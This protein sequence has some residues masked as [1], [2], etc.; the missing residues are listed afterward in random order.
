[1][2][3]FCLF[4]CCLLLFPVTV[5]AESLRLNIQGVE[6]DLQ[7]ILE[8]ALVLP[9]LL[10]SDETLNK[11]RLRYYQRQLPKTVNDILEPY[12][13]FHSQASSSLVQIEPGEY[14]L[15]I[16]VS[17]GEPLRISSFTLELSGPGADLPELYQRLDDFPLKVGD[18]LR[19]DH[20]DEGKSTLK[21]AAINIG[22]LDADF[23]RHQLLVN[24]GE[25]RVEIVLQ[26][27]SG[28]RYQFGKTSFSGR[29]NYPER[30]LRRFLVY[31]EGDNFSYNTL[32]RSQLSFL[33]ADLFRNVKVEALTEQKDENRIPVQIELEQL[34]RHRLRPGIGYGTDTGAR[35][36]LQYRELNLFERGHELQGELLIAER[37]QSILTTYIIPDL[38][39]RDSQTLFRVGVT[40]EE[41]DSYI[42]RKQ[43]SEGEYQR[44]YGKRLTG[45][46][47]LRL[48]SE[49]SRVADEST[50]SQMLLP[51]VRLAWKKVDDLL[52]PQRGILAS[53]ELQGSQESLL[54]DTSL[55]QLSGQVSTLMPLP[56]QSSLF[57]R[58][59]G[60][61][62]W[63]NDALRNLPASLRYFAGGD[64]SVRGYAYQSLGPK[65]DTGE[66][67]GGKHL[68]V[69]NLE[70]EKHLTQNWGAAVFYDVGNAFD[71][72]NSY[73][74]E[75]AAGIGVRRYTRI[76]AIRVD[77]ARQIGVS[78]AKYRLHLSVGLGW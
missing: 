72:F 4:L 16:D 7:D 45:S 51:G 39:R 61:T 31:R 15:R 6:K 24:R 71:S 33:D 30:F 27:D 34:P 12:G 11:R 55:L 76:G 43:F 9:S 63:H 19:Q 38:K 14:Q 78:D 46:L 10:D 13:Y 29:N 32:G 64:R 44:S 42:S 75:Q 54:S 66:V 37:E 73:E 26:L 56:R 25:R 59:K 68:L 67:V 48:T 22:Y 36:S 69:A 28:V 5:S 3:L 1:M 18:V 53:L 21:Q 50:R 35:L 47:F 74:L 70:L 2:R 23:T 20:Y 60:G 57:L 65:D 8:K 52:N 58:L 77:L 49:Y 41:T 17:P 40:R 62:T